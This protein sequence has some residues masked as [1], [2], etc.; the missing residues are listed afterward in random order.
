[1]IKNLQEY[2]E[3]EHILVLYWSKEL[4]LSF[5][6]N[7]LQ[8]LKHEHR[9]SDEQMTKLFDETW[10]YVTDMEYETPDVG[11]ALID[12]LREGLEESITELL[13]EVTDKELEIVDKELWEE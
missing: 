7:L 8:D 3:N 5:V 4:G 6:E 10:E 13:K 9:L 1:M 11:D 12:N 2:D